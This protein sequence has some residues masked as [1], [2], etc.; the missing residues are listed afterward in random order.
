LG[1]MTV[2]ERLFVTGLMD[3]FDKANK[4]DKEL[5]KFILQSIRVDEISIN[6]IL[7]I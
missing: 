3:T 1:G 7:K 5:A 4:K 6:K 2:N